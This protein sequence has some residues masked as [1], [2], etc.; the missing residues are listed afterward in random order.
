MKLEVEPAV[1][2]RFL[3]DVEVLRISDPTARRALAEALE[4]LWTN[5]WE[6]D[7]PVRLKDATRNKYE[8]R[9]NRNYVLVFRRT[10]LR[11]AKGELLGYRM[12]ILSL[13]RL[14]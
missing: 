8:Y 12:V 6:P 2:E 1:A 10:P 5:P 7:L 4:E 9:F 11:D 14:P 13:Q 3:L